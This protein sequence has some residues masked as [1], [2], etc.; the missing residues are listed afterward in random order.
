[1]TVRSRQVSR[2][3]APA[4]LKWRGA[5]T[6]TRSTLPAP[7]APA[8]C[9]LS[10]GSLRRAIADDLADLPE[11][12]GSVKRLGRLVVR[13]DAQHDVLEQRTGADLQ[14]PAHHRPADP[15]P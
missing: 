4:G 15:L 14:R 1:M 12:Q 5:P 9:R 7:F 8:F 6:R 10:C 13:R 11:A 3:P 2:P